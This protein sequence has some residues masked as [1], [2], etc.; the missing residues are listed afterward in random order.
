MRMELNTYHILNYTYHTLLILK[1]LILLT[2]LSQFPGSTH[3]K[4][5]KISSEDPLEVFALRGSI[6]DQNEA[7]KQMNWS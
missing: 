2:S 5:I 4:N 6:L 3:Y 7:K 1:D